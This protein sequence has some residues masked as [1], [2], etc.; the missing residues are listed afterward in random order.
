VALDKL[1]VTSL[2]I[3]VSLPLKASIKFTNMRG[4]LYSSVTYCQ[5]MLCA[6]MGLGC[7]VVD[8]VRDR[9]G[10]GLLLL[11]GLCIQIMLTFK[12]RNFLL[13]F[14]TPCI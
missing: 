7:R 10:V 1:C 6:Y 13:N 3:I 12:R 5:G 4:A 14:N 11:V 8:R 2:F 9:G